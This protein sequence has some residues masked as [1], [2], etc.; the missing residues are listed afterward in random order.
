MGSTE[1]TERA[2][3]VSGPIRIGGYWYAYC[4]AFMS[5]ENYEAR[6]CSCLFLSAVPNEAV[7]SPA[8]PAARFMIE[9]AAS[10]SPPMT[11]AAFGSCTT[12]AGR[13][14]TCA[15]DV[16]WMI[17]SCDS[18]PL[19]VS[20]MISELFLRPMLPLAMAAA[21]F[22]FSFMLFCLFMLLEACFLLADAPGCF[23]PEMEAPWAAE[24]FVTPSG[25]PIL[26]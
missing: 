2:S 17:L 15:A 14:C 24:P 5:P 8:E 6:R 9:P 13:L 12:V 4:I 19:K 16:Y 20:W 25:P 21:S 1:G 26:Y 11:L 22:R 23:E 10:T 18:P 7:A 3:P